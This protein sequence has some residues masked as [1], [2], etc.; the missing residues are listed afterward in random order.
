MKMNVCVCGGGNLGHVVAGFLAAR[1]C[2]GAV[3]VLTNRPEKWSRQITVT[4]S[5]TGS[6]TTSSISSVSSDPS[7][8]IPLADVV[9]LTLPSYCMADEMKRVKPFLKKEA[10]VGGIFSSTG[11]FFEGLKIFGHDVRMWGFQRV[12]F[13]ARLKEYGRSAE[14]LGHKSLLKIA[15]ENC[16]DEAKHRF[17]AWVEE[18]FATPT[19]LLGGYLEASI[20]NSNPL[21]HT[22]RLYTLCRSLGKGVWSGKVPLF[23]EDWTIEAA[24]LYI[25]MDEELFALIDKL[26]V[27]KDFLQRV[28]PYYESTDAASLCS[29]ISSIASFKGITTPAVEV[30][31]KC[32]R[33]DFKHRYFVEDFGY[34]LRYIWQLAQEYNVGT[35]NIN[36]VYEWGRACIANNE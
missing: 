19:E 4:D 28:L 5:E 8:V 11:F 32:F 21:L 30:S 29:K 25:D 12:P 33:P 23:Y 27:D 14:L 3:S 18:A 36:K 31:A 26:P 9:I 22:A 13:I 15:V 16:E 10:Y 24:Q 20:S 34:G 7:E 17:R 2:V 35:P 6:V 1:T